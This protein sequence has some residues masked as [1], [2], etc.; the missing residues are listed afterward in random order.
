MNRSR[1]GSLPKRFTF[2]LHRST[3]FR[4]LPVTLISVELS[5]PSTDKLLPEVHRLAEHWRPQ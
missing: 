5:Q 3:H 2:G 4:N 1:G